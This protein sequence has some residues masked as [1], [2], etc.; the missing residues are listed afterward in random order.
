LQWVD[1]VEIFTNNGQNF[2]TNGELRGSGPT[3]LAGSAR[4]ALNNWY[5]PI[6]N[7][8]RANPNCD[9]ATNPL[10]DRQLD[11]R[12]YVFVMMTDGADTC[13]G[14]N[15][16]T[17]CA[18][19]RTCSRGSD[20]PSG[21]CTFGQCT[22]SSDAQCGTNYRC[23]NS[24]CYD[25]RQLDNPPTIVQQ[26]RNTNTTNPVS[27]YVIGLAIVGNDPAVGV[28]NNMAAAGGTGTARFSNT[29]SQ[30]EAA[31]ADI[32][33]SSVRYE[34]C[35]NRDD[36][37]N[38]VIDEGFNKGLTCTVGV[39]A[40]QRSGIT[41]CNAAGSD[42]TC[43]V[44]D[45]NPNSAC[46]ALQPGA[47]RT[48]VCNNQDDDCDGLIDED[49][50]CQ[51]CTPTAEVCNGRDD[52]CDGVA[53][54]NLVDT[55][56]NCG[57][58]LGVCTP[59]RT[60]CVSGQLQCQGGTQPSPETCNNLDD[61]CDGVVDNFVR[62][63]YSGPAGTSGVG[64]CRPGQQR[65]LSGTFQ[66][67]VGEVLPTPESCNNVD[68]NCDGTI[69]N[70]AGAGGACCP[71]GNCNQGLCRPGSLQCSGGTLQ[72]LGAVGPSVEVCDGADNDCNGLVDDLPG[73]RRP[74]QPPGTNCPGL[75]ACDPQSGSIIC[76]AQ[77]PTTEV[78]DG[79]DNNCNGIIDDPAL[80]AQN[81]SRLGQACGGGANLPAPCRPGTTICS[82][83]QVVCQGGVGP[84]AEV[85]DNRDNDCDG[86]T[87]NGAQCPPNFSCVLGQCLAPCGSGEFPCAGGYTCDRQLNVCVPTRGCTPACGQCQTCR[88]GQCVDSCSLIS[89][90][91]GS[92]CQCGTC[93]INDCFEERCDPGEICDFTART[94]KTNP[95]SGV[96]CGAGQYCDPATGAC[97]AT[98][99]CPTGQRCDNGNCVSD[100]CAGKPCAAGTICTLP[101]GECRPDA[102]FG[103]TCQGGLVCV[104]GRCVRNPCDPVSCPTNYRCQANSTNGAVTCAPIPAADRDQI[105][106]V[107][108]GGFAC[109]VGATPS[110]DRGDATRMLLLG[111]ALVALGMR[112]RVR[113]RRDATP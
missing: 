22:C 110:Q 15:S 98:C 4:T 16:S 89:C 65:C 31:F 111:L 36:N 38:G 81:D 41:K 13:E 73:T 104:D 82:E 19:T 86:R 10:C 85:C 77:A 94:C 39:G 109:S 62:S 28:M 55:N 5:L 97:I 51:A 6:Y 67:C 17:G 49:G 87:D 113:S 54:N 68:D 27:T 79:I 75:T 83:G 58:Q 23:I 60:V 20:C 95:C 44:N 57:L 42:T 80:V 12:P 90:P 14:C 18:Q 40:C 35:N 59:G 84:T 100:P 76:Q 64:P 101:N 29:Q 96:S 25:T 112:R 43:C 92:I 7:Y 69:D 71:S 34:T 32:V 8:T 46:A 37:C 78:C 1:N 74:C 53:D 63:C 108:G 105:V 99:S 103:R 48:E 24:R 21:S 3:P 72:C 93:L 30:I 26:L 33:A 66:G 9:P 2:P 50:V 47:P 88:G 106:S 91:G 102:C 45:G 70:A 107:G 52:D 61:D 11:C 56:Q